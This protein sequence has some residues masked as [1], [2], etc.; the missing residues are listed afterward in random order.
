[1][2]LKLKKKILYLIGGSGKIG[3]DI[4]D[5][6]LKS[7]FKVVILDKIQS[8]KVYKNKNLSFEFI[9]LE[10]LNSIEK[11]LKN[12][13]KKYGV[14]DSLINSSYPTSKN[15]FNSNL[16]KI[17]ID[18]FT[19]NMNIHLGSFFWSAKIMADF[20]KKKGRKY[21]NDQLNLL[22]SFTRP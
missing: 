12:I 10:K 14:P 4:A 8:K 2:S 16:D 18:T 6:F 9:D 7:G 1:M 20:M 19:E 13:I 11:K 3:S 17:K 21:N 22:H 5:K 15:W